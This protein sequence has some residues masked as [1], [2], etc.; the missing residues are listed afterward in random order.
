L[1]I[2]ELKQIFCELRKA[3]DCVNHKLLMDKLKFYGIKGKFNILINSY[4][5]GRYQRVTLGNRSD[6][7]SKSKWEIIKCR[8]PQGSVLGLL[9]FL[10]YINDL[11]NLLTKNNNTVLFADDTSIIITDKNKLKLKIKLNQIFKQISRNSCNSPTRIH[12]DQGDITMATESRFLGLII[13]NTLSWKQQIE[14]VVNKLLVAC[15]ALRNIKYTVS[16]ETLRIIYFLMTY[17]I[18]FWGSSVYAHKD[19][20]MQKKI[21]RIITNSKPRYSCREIFKR[22]KMTLYSQYNLYIHYPYL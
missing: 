10:V 16:L 5:T 13:D 15:Y 18:M 9:F 8:V 4:L 21:I 20:T 2:K 17:G 1:L 6:S 11:P 22:I 12:C 3:F 14:Q 7:G 19:F